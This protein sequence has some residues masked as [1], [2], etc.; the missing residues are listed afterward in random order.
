MIGTNVNVSEEF[1]DDNKSDLNDRPSKRAR[2]VLFDDE[3]E[4]DCEEFA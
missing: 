1:I 2:S 4:S 3:K